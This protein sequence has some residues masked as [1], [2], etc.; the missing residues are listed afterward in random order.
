MVLPLGLIAGAIALSPTFMNIGTKVTKYYGKTGSLGRAG[1][2]GIGYGGGTAIG[3][4]LVPQF[5]RSK[6]SNTKAGFTMLDTMPYARSYARYPR[7]RYS[8]PSR[9]SRYRSRRPYRR[10]NSYSRNYRRY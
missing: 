7:R 8:Y 4:N 1:T 6:Y 9:Y 10:Y 2:F 5:G 3:F